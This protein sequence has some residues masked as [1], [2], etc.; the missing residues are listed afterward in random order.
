[1]LETVTIAYLCVLG[2]TIAGC[3]GLLGLIVVTLPRGSKEIAAAPQA[4][5]ASL[6]KGDA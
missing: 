2:L 1:M 5:P 4:A 3:L 6:P